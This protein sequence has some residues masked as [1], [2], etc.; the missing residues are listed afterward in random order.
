[1]KRKL[2]ALAS[3]LALCLSLAGCTIST[4]DTVGTINGMEISS[5][6]YLLAQFDA[7]QQAAQ[8]AGEDQD[9]SSVRSFLNETITLDDGSSTTVSDYVADTTLADL[10]RFVAVETRFEE[11]GQTLSEEYASQADSYTD[12]VMENYGSLYEA[13]GIG[14]ETIRRYEYNLFKQAALVDLLYGENGETP[15]TDAQLTDHLENEMI[16]ARYI[17]VPLYNT[18]TFAFAD[19]DQSAE[20]LQLAQQAAADG[21]ADPDTFEIT[22]GEALPDIYAVLDAEYTAEDAASDFT[23]GFLTQSDLDNYFTADAAETLRALDFG[24]AAAVQYNAYSLLI[25]LRVD[26]LD[27]LSLD[28]LRST[29]LSDMGAGLVEDAMTELGASYDADLD[30]SAMNQLPARK[31]KMSV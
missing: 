13:N 30:E 2:L 16:Y 5:G 18:S 3:A 11:L 1:M 22:V 23:T 21:A 12:Q 20:M 14:E 25:A 10:R 28:L 27:T 4:P 29:I 24:E 19:E 6:L 26:P 9:P 8:Y 15:L 17:V 31:I 7:Y